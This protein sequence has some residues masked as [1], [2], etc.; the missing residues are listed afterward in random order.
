MKSRRGKDAC[1]RQRAEKA[2]STEVTARVRYFRDPLLFTG[3]EMEGETRLRGHA[4]PVK[5]PLGIIT[6]C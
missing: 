3:L 6:S 2:Q 5:P 1:C 4:R